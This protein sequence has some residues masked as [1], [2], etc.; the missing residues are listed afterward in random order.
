[1]GWLVF[2][3]RIYFSFRLVGIFKQVAC[4]CNCNKVEFYMHL[5]KSR[6]LSQDFLKIESCNHY[7]N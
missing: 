2:T 3:V 1:M 6:T 4:S 5:E 7:L